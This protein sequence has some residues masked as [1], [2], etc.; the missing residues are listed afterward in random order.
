[1]YGQII[2]V[3]YSIL[4]LFVDSETQYNDKR[5]HR[6]GSI[7]TLFILKLL[8][9]FGLGC[10]RTKNKRS[11]PSSLVVLFLDSETPNN[12]E[13]THR[14]GRIGTSFSLTCEARLVGDDINRCVKFLKAALV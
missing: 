5:T 12:G 6:A 10:G 3:D 13:W 7:G 1:M 11:L 2:S 8:S 9:S 4:V 14:A